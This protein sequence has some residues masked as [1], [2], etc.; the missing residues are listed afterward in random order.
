MSLPKSTDWALSMINPWEISTLSWCAG[1]LLIRG[2]IAM[3]DHLVIALVELTQ[4]PKLPTRL[5]DK[6]VRYV[7]L[8][9][10][11]VVYLIV[12]ALQ[13]WV[14]VQNLCHFIWHSDNVPKD[15][16]EL[17]PLNTAAALYLMFLVLDFL[18]APMHCFLHWRPVYPWIHKHHHRQIFPVRG[19]LDAGN[20][21][22]VEHFIGTSCT[23]LA[24]IT[25][26]HITGAHA[27]TIFL[28]FNVHAA[29][30]MLNHSPYDV[31]VTLLGLNYSVK[32]HEMH[33]RKFTTNYA[34]YWMG[35]DRLMGTFSPYNSTTSSS[36]DGGSLSSSSK[37]NK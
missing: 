8:N 9:S 20:E 12:N 11:S 2:A 13:E 37:K 7:G 29:L 33:H 25:S 32:A 28:F 15:W 34:Q 31:D 10:A 23:W 22:P 21:H 3:Y 26:V 5:A 6:P 4:Q 24:V 36:D 19:Y 16:H 1:F 14:F 27:I 17:Q 30:A 18:Y 35:M